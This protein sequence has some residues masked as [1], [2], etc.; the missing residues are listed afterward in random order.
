M[1]RLEILIRRNIS[2]LTDTW[3]WT[4]V[5]RMI[6]FEDDRQFSHIDLM[7][8]LV[9][10][11]SSATRLWVF[12]QSDKNEISQSSPRQN[13][14][15]RLFRGIAFRAVI[16]TIYLSDCQGGRRGVLADS[17]MLVS[18]ENIDSFIPSWTCLGW[19]LCSSN[20][21]PLHNELSVVL[22]VVLC[23]VLFPTL[24][25]FFTPESVR[26][27][28]GSVCQFDHTLIRSSI[29]THFRTEVFK[30]D[31]FYLFHFSTFDFI[32]HGLNR[33]NV[34]L[35]SKI[36]QR[37]VEIRINI[38]YALLFFYVLQLVTQYQVRNKINQNLANS[39]SWF[40][41]SWR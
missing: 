37:H 36:D 32:S 11:P 25:H 31:W 19:V 5:S 3:S 20:S 8:L 22:S 41:H 40:L 13:K 9:T 24:F 14:R 15:Q 33:C 38:I 21:L 2:H 23:S 1:W 34:M 7:V 10:A 6:A 29:W 12:I 26:L 17:Q 28:P 35:K 18:P 4:I 27:V 30:F 16:L 39:G